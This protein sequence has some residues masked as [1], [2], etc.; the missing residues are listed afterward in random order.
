MDRTSTLS[1][2]GIDADTKR[3]LRILAARNGRSMEEE[4]R[5]LIRAAVT[6]KP[7]QAASGLGSRIRGR[8]QGLGVTELER[9]T[10]ADLP[11]PYF[12]DDD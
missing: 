7:D 6:S 3:K 8:F 2:R 11:D 5:G 12:G 9:P 4:V 1:I 10:I